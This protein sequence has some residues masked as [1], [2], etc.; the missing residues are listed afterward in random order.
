MRVYFPSFQVQKLRLR[1]LKYIGNG[2]LS[3]K[4]KKNQSQDL[5]PGLT[6]K[7]MSLTK[8]LPCLIEGNEL[9]PT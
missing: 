1:E 6:L 7:P 5:K 4:K 9:N 8:V 3:I 2:R